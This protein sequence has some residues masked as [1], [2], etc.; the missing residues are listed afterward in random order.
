MLQ[1][2]PVVNHK[3]GV[4]KT[5]TA[6]NLAAGLAAAGR[7]VLLLDLDSQGS[8]TLSLGL[9]PE[10]PGCAAALYRTAHLA[11]TVQATSVP[12]LFVSPGTLALSHVDVRLA[13]VPIRVGRLRQVL[14]SVRDDYDVI[15]LDCSPST[16]LLTMNA[17]V[18]ADA[19]V[20]PVT[21]DYLAIQGLMSFGH[22]VRNV[23][24]AIGRLAPVLGIALTKANPGRAITSD[25]HG[26]L[27]DRFGGKVFDTVV[28]SDDALRA[29]PAHG[30][31]ISS[32]APESDGAED[33]AALTAEVA[34]RIDRYSAIFSSPAAGV[35]T[36]ERAA[37]VER[38]AA[39][40]LAA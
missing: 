10:T 35:V 1:V 22:L 40:R 12:N 9:N 14:A 7:R 31:P 24:A 27:R 11:D 29:A 8:A 34:S 19:L 15:L 39:L 5:T 30:Q 3:G 36:N 25:V 33:Y 37:A 13:A 4:G 38:A 32:F 6:V 16:S 28:R 2:I 26:M 20:I 21:P 23:R 18:A 17:L